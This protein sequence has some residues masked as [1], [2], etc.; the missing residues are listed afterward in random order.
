M[1]YGD[2]FSARHVLALS[3]VWVTSEQYALTRLPS[4][5]LLQAN[6]SSPRAR[7]SGEGLSERNTLRVCGRSMERLGFGKKYAVPGMFT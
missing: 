6:S 2:H 5:R 7:A 3:I 1:S 4:V